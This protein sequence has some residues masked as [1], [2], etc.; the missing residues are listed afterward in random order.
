MT[1][2]PEPYFGMFKKFKEYFM[3]ETEIIGDKAMLEENKIIEEILSATYELKNLY[4]ITSTTPFD[5]E[6]RYQKLEPSIIKE[7]NYKSSPPQANTMDICFLMDCTGS[8]GEWIKGC[9]D[10]VIAIIDL[11]TKQF[12]QIDI[13]LS[14]IGYHD[15]G[16]SPRFD[17]H[18]FTKKIPKIKE[19]IE[20]KMPCQ[21]RRRYP[22]RYL[23]RL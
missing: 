3:S 15:I 7:K 1:K 2:P 9:R 19:F 18:P 22:G 8:M 21:R 17:I 16:D 11:I 14:F 23:R 5:W 10:Q 20:K 4:S 6:K 13:N 12:P